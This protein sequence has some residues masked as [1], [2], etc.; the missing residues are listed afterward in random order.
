MLLWDGAADGGT[1][2]GY[3]SDAR[4]AFE[5]AAIARFK[6]GR[7]TLET[8]YLD[9][10]DLP[11]ADSG[12]RL[13]GANYEIAFGEHTRL[14]ATYMKWF[15]RRDPRRDGLDVYNLRAYAAPFPKLQGLSFEAEYA[16]EDN[17]GLRDSHAWTG[18]VAYE[19]G[20]A[21]KPK[22]SYRYARFLGDDPA[23]RANESFDP[24]W[25]GFYDWGTWWQGEIAGEYFVPNSN[26]VSHQ[27]RL[28]LAPSDALSTGLI[29]YALSLDQPG[30]LAPG[31]TARDVAFEL[32]L[33]LDWKLNANFTL[34]V[35]GAFA[36]PGKA[37]QQAFDRTKNFG[38]GMVYIS[39]SY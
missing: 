35:V 38:Y 27:A 36:N 30:A 23:T 15:A 19:L 29:A 11:E 4:K 12:S 7:H 1:R 34:S 31:V 17:G 13:W 26:L 39:Y 21:W 16:R 20:V 33:Y 6:P 37:V 10:D 2:G 5:F 25:A 24:L 22:L 14:G 9:K 8:F 3:W 32:D 18:Q 28:H